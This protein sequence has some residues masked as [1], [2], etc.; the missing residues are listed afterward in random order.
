MWH[1]AMLP[2]SVMAKGRIYISH[3]NRPKT[4][5]K[6]F[7]DSY[8]AVKL[9]ANNRK[10]FT[11]QYVYTAPWY[12]WDFDSATLTR[13][14]LGLLFLSLSG[15]FSFCFSSTR[16]IAITSNPREM[17]PAILAMVLHVFELFALARFF[18]LRQKVTKLDFDYC[19][20]IIGA[21][22]VYRGFLLLIAAGIGIC[23]MVENMAS[24]PEIAQIVVGNLVCS[25]L[26]F[27]LDKNYKKLPKKTME[28]NTLDDLQKS[29]K[30]LEEGS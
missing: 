12:S 2:K 16:P 4:F 22:P 18:L 26:A 20:G 30:L 5:H 24:A 15:F 27:A 17:I 11:I 25:S 8:T 10:G 21:F 23:E 9:K 28:N 3:A 1:V 13:K 29:G 19:D 6:R 14:K 7:Q